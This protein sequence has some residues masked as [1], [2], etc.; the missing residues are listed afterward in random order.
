MNAELQ[1]LRTKEKLTLEE[2]EK[3]KTARN[4]LQ[5]KVSELRL[6][7]DTSRK[8]AVDLEEKVQLKDKIVK[9]LHLIIEDRNGELQKRDAEKDQLQQ[10]K[11]RNEIL[12]IDNSNLEQ[13]LASVRLQLDS[14]EEETAI[15][16]EKLELL[17]KKVG[18]LQSTLAERNVQ[19]KEADDRKVQENETQQCKEGSSKPNVVM[20]T[21]TGNSS[22]SSPEPHNLRTTVDHDTSAPKQQQRQTKNI[23]FIG[24]SYVRDLAKLG[25]KTLLI[26]SV[27]YK[28]EYIASPGGTFQ[29]FLRKPAFFQRLQASEP[30][31]TFVILGGKDLKMNINLQDIFD[32]CQAFYRMVKD[33]IPNSCIIASEIENRFYKPNNRWGW[34]EGAFDVMRRRF[35]NW[36][37][38]KSFKH[39]L[40]KIQGPLDHEENYRDGVH[41]GRIGMDRYCNILDSTISYVNVKTSRQSH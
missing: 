37:Q 16:N 3:L 33:Y 20:Q 6:Q 17:D 34:K 8:V 19:L 9:D 27:Q 30:D 12:E 7:L 4:L 32:D 1:E 36:L 15:L 40:L 24:H 31:F 25:H 26:D 5:A 18:L 21:P 23:T 41:L 10:M 39:Y 29:T 28:L 35:S 13:K 22:S 11:D 2:N 38:K 14:K